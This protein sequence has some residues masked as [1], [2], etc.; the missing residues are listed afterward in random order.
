MSSGT[1]RIEG[2]V[3]AWEERRLGADEEYVAVSEIDEAL[4]DRSAGMKM[5]SIRLPESLIDD[6][7]DLA[8]I[9][10]LGYQPLMRQI[11]ERF[12][13]SEKKRLLNKYAAQMAK[14]AKKEQAEDD[15]DSEKKIA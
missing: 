3:E 13:E 9:H 4:V 15:G 11:L 2:T 1:D 10:G 12:A 14:Q 6:F 8:Q 5:I 7:K